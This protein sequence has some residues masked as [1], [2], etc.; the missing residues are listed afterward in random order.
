[1]R[2]SLGLWMTV[3]ARNVSVIR[4]ACNSSFDTIRPACISRPNRIRHH[5]ESKCVPR[6][7]NCNTEHYANAM[8]IMSGDI[9]G[10]E[11]DT[12]SSWSSGSLSDRRGEQERKCPSLGDVRQ[13]VGSF[14]QFL[15]NSILVDL[16]N[17]CSSVI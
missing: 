7:L 13:A 5:E 4:P 1:M 11:I 14:Q 10:A 6:G 2:R 12:S 3:Y 17:V 9:Q 8:A 16:C 15:H